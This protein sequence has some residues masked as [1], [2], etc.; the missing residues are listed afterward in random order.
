MKKSLTQHYA[1]TQCSIRGP[2]CDHDD[3][4]EHTYLETHEDG[5]FTQY[6][7]GVVAYFDLLWSLILLFFVFFIISGF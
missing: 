4:V 3:K 1:L 7:Y 2:I 6:G 5:I